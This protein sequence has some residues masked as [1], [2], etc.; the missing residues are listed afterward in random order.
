ME[1]FKAI[2]AIILSAFIFSTLFMD[3]HDG[4]RAVAHSPP[5]KKLRMKALF[6]SGLTSAIPTKL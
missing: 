1:K 4:G 2:T 6:I 3:G 5:M